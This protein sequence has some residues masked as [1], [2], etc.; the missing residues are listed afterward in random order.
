MYAE[1]TLEA[2]PKW[3]GRPVLI[4]RQKRRAQWAAHVVKNSGMPL[5][6]CA[7]YMVLIDRP[8]RWE[9]RQSWVVSEGYA[10]EKRV[11]RMF[12]DMIQAGRMRMARRHGPDGKLISGIYELADEPKW[13]PEAVENPCID[14]GFQDGPEALEC[15]AKA[16][17]GR[18]P[19]RRVDI[20]NSRIHPVTDTSPGPVDSSVAPPDLEAESRSRGSK[21]FVTNQAERRVGGATS[22]PEKEPGSRPAKGSAMRGAASGGGDQTAKD[23]YSERRIAQMVDAASVPGS[24]MPNPRKAAGAVSCLIQWHEEGL[25]FERDVLPAISDV[26]SR[27]GDPEKQIV[28]WRYFIGAIRD[29]RA[30]RLAAPRPERRGDQDQIDWS[31]R[32]TLYLNDASRRWPA[33]W[34]PRPAEPGCLVPDEA[35]QKFV[36]RHHVYLQRHYVPGLS[37]AL[38]K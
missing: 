33:K 23:R 1:L 37:E 7:L 38:K 31:H 14:D 18:A 34:G 20:D 3:A 28:S 5:D 9:L 21:A 22:L 27:V 29:R 4:Q 13:L 16:Q 30:Q 15:E 19:Q 8:E 36:L 11:R 2:P 26:C 10:K 17:Q 6:T 24:R 12:N 32:L 25:D 35:I